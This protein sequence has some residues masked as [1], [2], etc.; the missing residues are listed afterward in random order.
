MA[1]IS[2][3]TDN[4]AD[5][6]PAI[7]AQYG[8]TVV[9]L[10]VRFG[11]ETFMDTELAPGEFWSRAQVSPPH[12]SGAALGG[13]VS[14]FQRLVSE[15]SHVLCLTLTGRHSTVFGSAWT[16]AKEFGD[17][18]TVCDSESISWGLGWQAI[19]A[20]EAAA[21]G[22]PLEQIIEAAK[23]VRSRM[24]IQ[25]VLDTVSFVRRGG[26]ADHFISV[27]DK[28]ARTLSIKPT[29]TF[30]GGEMKLANLSRTWERGVRRIIAEIG[31]RAPLD[32]LAIGHTM[33]RERAEQVADEIAADT[34]YPRANIHVFEPG[35][36]IAS[37]S[38]PGLL[39]ALALSSH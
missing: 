8:I 24:S 7:A 23:D 6:P 19:A 22:L 17:R 28:A 3:V 2:V 26:R 31:Q 38:G 10:I 16:A 13:F 39:G 15:G 27:I 35:V 9:P 5:L 4:S 29:L 11:D 34:G 1:E 33:R 36:A 12:T 20:A 30:V 32:G 14:A 25:L 37:H 18:V 21:R